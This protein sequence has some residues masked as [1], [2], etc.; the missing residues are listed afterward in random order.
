MIVYTKHFI[1]P[2]VC[3]NGSK[4]ISVTKKA[5]LHLWDTILHEQE[6]KETR[7]WG[8][9]NYIRIEIPLPLYKLFAGNQKDYYITVLPSEIDGEKAIASIYK[10]EEWVSPA[11]RLKNLTPFSITD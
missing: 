5:Y 9:E 6:V 7:V 4:I 2:D 11:S 10:V 1:E 8:G 3:Y